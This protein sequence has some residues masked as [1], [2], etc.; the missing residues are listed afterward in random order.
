M[1]GNGIQ[2]RSVAIEKYE[3]ISD[4]AMALAENMVEKYANK[5]LDISE[6]KAR[7]YADRFWLVIKK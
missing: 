7:I 5:S 4:D 6:I 2:I 1:N 3:N